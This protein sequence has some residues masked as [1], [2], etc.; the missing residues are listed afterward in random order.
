MKGGGNIKKKIG[1]ESRHGC[2][3]HVDSLEYGSCGP[4][5]NVVLHGLNAW[6]QWVRRNEKYAYL[7]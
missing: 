5:G 1:M 2:Q 3:F 7:M 6:H 4:V